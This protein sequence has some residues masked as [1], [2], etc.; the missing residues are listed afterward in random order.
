MLVHECAL[1]QY[2]L[3][4]WRNN[5]HFSNAPRRR[6]DR[7]RWVSVAISTLSTDREKHARRYRP[8][9]PSS[10]GFHAVMRAHKLDPH[11]CVR[12]RH[13]LENLQAAGYYGLAGAGEAALRRPVVRI[14]SVLDL[15]RHAFA[16]RASEIARD[17]F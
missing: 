5:N 4:A 10:A 17:P 15:P 2:A 9:K 12:R 3:C 13:M 14:G 6:A 11:R 1:R 7:A 16:T 8:P